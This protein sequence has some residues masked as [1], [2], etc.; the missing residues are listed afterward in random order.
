MMGYERAWVVCSMDGMV[1]CNEKTGDPQEFKTERSA[2]KLA[3]EW[4]KNSSDEQAWVFRLSHVVSRSDEVKVE[5]V[6]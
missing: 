6:E 3:R 5:E 4:V 1:L 2:L